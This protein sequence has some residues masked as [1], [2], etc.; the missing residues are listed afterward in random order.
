M[1]TIKITSG[2]SR[3]P[4]L[5]IGPSTNVYVGPE[6]VHYT[7]PKRLLYGFSD[8][9]KKCLEGDFFEAR[10][11][12]V[13]LPDV[14]PDVFQW[15]WQWLYTGHLDFIDDCYL[16]DANGLVPCGMLCQLHMLGER[17]LMGTPFFY[18]VRGK[19]DKFIEEAIEDVKQRGTPM[20][21]MAEII[22]QVLSDSA[23]FQYCGWRWNFADLSLRPYLLEQLCDFTFCT[24]FDFFS[25]VGSFELDGAFAAHM[26]MY[27]AEELKWA[28]ELWGAQTQSSID[29][30]GKKLQEAQDN[31]DFLTITKRPK[32]K[33]GIWLALRYACT[34]SGCTT[35]DF[36]KYSRCFELDG[37]FAA[38][39][40]D[41]MGSE[42]KW[43]VE[44]WGQERGPKVDVMQ[45]RE[46]E[47]WNEEDYTNIERLSWKTSYV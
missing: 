16:W 40:L 47:R 21:W 33:E 6:E 12:A 45:E 44:K 46:D 19:L 25:C 15:L 24:T 3:L 17:L 4:R 14:R 28:V 9:A 32:G 43:V 26:M 20:P 7:I 18:D 31:G 30:E 35:T 23:P 42:L 10:A 41:F 2:Y 37:L 36:L 5:L 34:F 38:E 1:G 13:W 11:N 8:F 29:I 22:H 27:L 39:I